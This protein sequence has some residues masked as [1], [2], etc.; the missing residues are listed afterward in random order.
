MKNHT[1]FILSPITEIL[2]NAVTASA[3][4]GSGIE[5][6]PLYDYI[7]Q[8]I[9]LKMTGYQEQ[10]MKCIWWE[11]ATN[12]YDYRYSEMRSNKLGECSKYE[13]KN[14][15]Y[16][17]L[18]NQIIKHCDNFEI[19][20]LEKNNI[21]NETILN[22]EETFTNTNFSIWAQDNFNEFFKNNIIK[23]EH[24][25]VKTKSEI[26]LFIDPLNKIYTALYNHRNICAHNTKSYQ[27][28]LPTLKTLTSENYRYENY[29]IWFALLILIDKIFILLFNKYLEVYEN[30]I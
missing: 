5:T 28:N 6:Y 14:K 17:D 15:I 27:Q 12:D 9:F 29:F 8:S 11:M 26:N 16:K 2:N 1:D 19:T 20:I 10:K 7:M 24:F 25:I 18:T 4:I 23:V 30:S 22:I 3:G 13:E 21:L